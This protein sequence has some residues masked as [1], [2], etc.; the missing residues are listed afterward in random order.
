[1]RVRGAVV[2]VTGASSGIG[3]ETALAFAKAGSTVVGAA[4]RKD[5]LDQLVST[6]EQGGGKALAVECDVSEREQ[7]DGLRRTVDEAFGR[8]DV[9]V[10]NA[11]VAGGGPFTK[12][13]VE[14]IERVVRIN[15]IGLLYCT[16]AFLPGML[17]ARRG[18][19]VNI[20]SLAG[21]YAVPGSSVYSSTKHAVVA[22]SEALYY[23]LASDGVRVTTVNPSFVRTEGFSA[24]DLEK[25]PKAILLDADQ[26]AEAIVDVVKK[27]KA[28]EVS[29]PR[30]MASMQSVRVLAPPLYRAAL[31]RMARRGVSTRKL[32][33]E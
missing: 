7:V 1:M 17:E 9:L 30:W 10:N 25:L 15:Y 27:E 3:W 26:V 13:S 20:A 2:V 23:E 21:R 29:V 31:K 12:L 19:I 33:D 5:R 22:F 28:P 14:Q 24:G 11:G 18:H 32:R 4:R 8:C 6:I 16:K